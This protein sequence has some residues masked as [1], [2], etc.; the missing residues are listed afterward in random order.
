M[1][2]IEIKEIFDVL[3]T[4]DKVCIT[5]HGNATT[6]IV[7]SRDATHVYVTSGKVRSSPAP[8]GVLVD[9]GVRFGIQYQ[10]TMLQPIRV[11][12]RLKIV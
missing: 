12:Q 11:V 7:T 3:Q 2:R 5:S 8:G 1:T 9:H 4:G 6:R 10:P